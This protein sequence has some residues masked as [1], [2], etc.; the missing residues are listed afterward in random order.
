M[1]KSPFSV[2]MGWPPR[3]RSMM[4]SR[5]LASPTEGRPAP[6]CGPSAKGESLAWPVAHSS[7]L[8]GLLGPGAVD[9]NQVGREQGVGA[10][11]EE[12]RDDSQGADD[13]PNQA[14]GDPPSSGVA[15][16]PE[17]EVAPDVVGE[18]Q[19]RVV[20]DRCLDQEG[21]AHA[22]QVVAFEH[23]RIE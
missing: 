12:S 8:S 17:G 18:E 10:P 11:G 5:L 19:G 3:G 13:P 9:R 2:D 16:V 21:P 22:P 23:G 1:V 6:R 20:P 4:A 7:A 15:A 14:L